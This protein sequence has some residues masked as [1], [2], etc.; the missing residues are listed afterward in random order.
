MTAYIGIDIAKDKFDILLLRDAQEPEPATFA[1]TQQGWNQC[2][3]FLKKRQAQAAQVCMEATGI[4]Y[5]EL[6]HFL[7]Q[8]GY[9]VSVV[10]PLQI[11]AYAQSQL[12]RTKTD[13]V[14]AAIIADFCRT[15]ALPLWTPPDPA[16]YELRALVRHL[17]DLETDRQRQRNRRDA[18][19]RSAQPSS[20]VLSNLHDQIA[21]LTQQIE[22]VKQ[23]IQHHI[24]QHPDLKQQRDLLDS[25]KGIGPLTAAKL[26]AEYGDMTHFDTVR[27]VVAF[28]GLNPK[29]RQSGSSVRG[30]TP[31][32]KIGRSSIR[33]ALYMPAIN[34]K[35]FNPLL[36]PFVHRLAR[37]GL[38]ESEI[39]VAVMRKLLHL[40]FGVLKSGQP[41]DPHYLEKRAAFA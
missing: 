31:I 41:F 3:R 34:A 24:D 35:R 17:E 8:K 14:D 1:N 38:C 13:R 21:F 26:L 12:R 30:K 36:Q 37:Q 39:I 33:A 20:T 25:I 22:A 27:Q 29:H 23:Q 32:S 4:Y 16:W 19:T 15:Q 28:A 40:A 11:K 10:N 9:R 6:A 7:H 2:H 5:E 18:L